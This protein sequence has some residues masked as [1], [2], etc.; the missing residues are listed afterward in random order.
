M[1][2]LDYL[3]LDLITKIN[4]FHSYS[5]Y[6]NKI[7]EDNVVNDEFIL[8][9]YPGLIDDEDFK[10]FLKEIKPIVRKEV[11]Y[12]LDLFLCIKKHKIFQDKILFLSKDLDEHMYKE[13]FKELNLARNEILNIL[14]DLNYNNNKEVF[15]KLLSK[16]DTNLKNKILIDSSILNKEVFEDLKKD[17]DFVNN[18]NF[19]KKLI[20][21][22]LC[23]SF[24]HEEL[25]VAAIIKERGDTYLYPALCNASDPSLTHQQGL[26]ESQA[27]TEIESK[28]KFVEDLFLKIFSLMKYLQKNNLIS[29]NNFMDK[30]KKE[31]TNFYN[32]DKTEQYKIKKGE[33]RKRRLRPGLIIIGYKDI[34]NNMKD[35][36]EVL[37]LKDFK[38]IF[39]LNIKFDLLEN[40]NKL[41]DRIKYLDDV[42]VKDFKTLYLN[43][44]KIFD[45]QE[46]ISKIKQDLR[47]TNIE[48]QAKTI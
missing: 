3:E 25:G 8:K 28:L 12:I 26:L 41:L 19:I 10:N 1:E 36:L 35:E 4:K 33:T 38:D 42:F 18:L 43:V 45:I 17:D 23:P 39:S 2:N 11:K 21:K 32:L 48:Y 6:L 27:E 37:I 24:R 31:L 20:K 14:T 40:K 5:N 7:D 44:N 15:T 29:N 22:D 46:F 30:Y 47:E 34:L 9:Y 16:V 13:L